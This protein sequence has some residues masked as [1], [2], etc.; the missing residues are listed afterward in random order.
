VK[1]AGAA[2]LPA[3]AVVDDPCID[4]ELCEYANTCP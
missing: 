1:P 4:P 2:F 3:A